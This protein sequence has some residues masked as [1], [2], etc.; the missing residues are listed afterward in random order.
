MA[1]AL[2]NAGH[3]VQGERWDNE[4]IVS[5]DPKW[6]AEGGEEEGEAQDHH[7]A[8]ESEPKGVISKLTQMFTGLFK[9]DRGDFTSQELGGITAQELVVL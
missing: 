7:L 8:E 2:S 3:I 4:P 6:G 9:K 1:P 5:Y